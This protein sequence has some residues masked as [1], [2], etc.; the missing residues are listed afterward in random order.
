V[1]GFQG[2]YFALV[3]DPRSLVDSASESVSLSDGPESVLS[4]ALSVS[5]ALSVSESTLP[6]TARR[7]VAERDGA[8]AAPA[9]AAEPPVA[10][11][12]GG[13][14]LLLPAE[15]ADDDFRGE[16]LLLFTVPP[17]PL[18]PLPG[19]LPDEDIPAPYM[20]T[21]AAQ[22]V[23]TDEDAA[24]ALV[25]E[26]ATPLDALPVPVPAAAPEV[27]IPGRDARADPLPPLLPNVWYPP[28]K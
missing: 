26:D 3:A 14:P 25:D 18:P 21:L 16:S 6:E 22:A 10:A 1:V 12:D 7:P 27:V 23:G 9:V 13:L 15:D 17:P 2:V 4:S 28:W 19:A 5:A 24:D 11:L 20:R 8:T